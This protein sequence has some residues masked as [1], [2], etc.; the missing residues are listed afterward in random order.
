MESQ[1]FSD[2][3]AE[4][5]EVMGAWACV[6]LDPVVERLPVVMRKPNP[7]SAIEWFCRGVLDAVAGV[8][9]AVKVQS[10]CFERYG[11]DGVSAYHRVVSAARTAGLV[12][13]GDVKRGDIGVSAEHY[14]AGL[15]GAVPRVLGAATGADRP[16]LVG[17]GGEAAHSSSASAGIG[18]DNEAAGGLGEANDW[19]SL[20][21]QRGADALTVSG[22]MGMETVEPF[23]AAAEGTGRGV[24]VLVR[25][26]NPGSG[27]FQGLRLD[28][29][30]TVAEAVADAVAARGESWGGERGW[31]GLG[32]GVGGGAGGVSFGG[33]GGWRGGGGVVGATRVEEAAGLRERMPRQIFL[34]PGYG[35]Q[36][37]GMDGVRACRGP[38]G[39]GALV[40]A[41]RSVLYPE[42]GAA[43]DWQMAVKEAAKRF[44]EEV[45]E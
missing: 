30:R 19:V 23:L 10:A 3:L 14:A 32:G 43:G 35:A 9:P 7:V 8:V 34:V 4:A 33:A 29:G 41:S 40:T 20:S 5:C 36:G 12:V 22:Y 25:T 38:D 24:F 11:G 42:G 27:D 31:S 39:G 21:Q 6:G 17:A 28:D 26:S 45:G 2:R 13:I 18:L 15:L 1:A 44:V 16:A 37:G